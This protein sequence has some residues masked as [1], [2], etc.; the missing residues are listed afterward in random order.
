MIFWISWLL[1]APLVFIILP[2]RIIGKK[3]VKTVKKSAAITSCNH[4][5]LGDPIILKARVNTAYKL[6]AKDSLFKKKLSGWYL[7][8]L[9]AYPVKRGENDI[10]VVRKT[11]GFLKDDKHLVFSL[12]GLEAKLKK[13]LN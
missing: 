13:C 2:T 6:M 1:L 10:G 12:R 3:Y 11:L 9:G 4:Q 5:S 8:K 7:T